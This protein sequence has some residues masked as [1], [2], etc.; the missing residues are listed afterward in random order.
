MFSDYKIVSPT[1]HLNQLQVHS[2]QCRP[3]FYLLRI[4]FSFCFKSNTIVLVLPLRRRTIANLKLTTGISFTN[5]RKKQ[6]YV[7]DTYSISNTNIN[8]KKKTLKKIGL[9]IINT[10]S[11]RKTNFLSFFFPITKD[12][13]KLTP[14][15]FFS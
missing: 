4:K 3:I 13:N 14:A 10:N 11:L 15:S 2:A 1:S 9:C 12:N 6:Y 8:R 7:I 5:G